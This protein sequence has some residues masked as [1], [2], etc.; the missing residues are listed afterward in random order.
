VPCGST[1]SPDPVAARASRTHRWS[2]PAPSGTPG[3]PARLRSSRTPPRWPG[4]RA[5]PARTRRWPSAASGAGTPP[6]SA[7]GHRRSHTVKQ[8]LQW[9]RPEPPARLG[10][11]ARGRDSPRVVPAPPRRQGLGQPGR[12]LLVVLGRYL[13]PF[14]EKPWW[15]ASLA[16]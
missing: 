14:W 4:Y 5:R 13:K 12:D 15:E 8:Q 11:P 7:P 6:G 1:C 2:P 3:A 16:S 10:D 9:L